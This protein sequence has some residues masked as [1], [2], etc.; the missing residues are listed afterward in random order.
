MVI[1]NTFSYEVWNQPLVGYNYSYFNPRNKQRTKN[2][3]DEL[4]DFTVAL[5]EGNMPQSIRSPIPLNDRLH[6]NI[7]EDYGACH[8]ITDKHVSNN[9][10]TSSSNNN[11]GFFNLSDCK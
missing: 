4:Y 1:D 9:A 8:L 10:A 7:I 11:G 2:L 6:Q 3:D 5:T